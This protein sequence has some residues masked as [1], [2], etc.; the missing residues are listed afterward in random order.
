MSRPSKR[1]R[2]GSWAGLGFASPAMAFIIVFF[3]VPAIVS[4]ALSLMTFDIYA[5]S[6]LGNVRFVG[7]DNYA[8]LFSMPLFWKAMGNTAYFVLLGAP[9]SVAVSLGAALL[10]NAPAARFKGFYRALFFTPFVTTLV[11]TAVIW[12][13][14]LH[15]RYGLVNQSLGMAGLGPV[16]WLGN[17]AA[18]MPAIVLFS[19]WKNFG[20]A[21]MLFLAGLQTIPRDLYEAARIDGAGAWAQFRHVTLPGIAPVLLVV[22]IM[23]VANY[24][25]LFAEPYVMTQGEPAQSTVSI[26]YLMFEQ[27][28]KWW[29]LGFASTVAFVLF[30]IMLTV[31]LLQLALARRQGA[32]G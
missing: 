21:M 25:Q 15:T 30:V 11:A 13:Y 8:R 10:V 12:R 29:D 24:F 9:L 26:L 7:L 5:L 17:P 28:F 19:V 3:F 32:M 18:S 2:A 31:S 1:V 4:L 22:S 27:G 14:L 20:Y 16:D 6:D 23:T